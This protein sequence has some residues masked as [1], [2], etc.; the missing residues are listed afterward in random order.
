MGKAQSPLLGFNNNVKHR[1]RVFHIQT[2]D[3]GIKY[4]HVITH[5]FAD[6]GRILKSVKTSYAEYLG[7]EDLQETVRNL[8]KEQH[9]SMF[10]ALRDGQFDDL[11]EEGSSEPS[12][13][14]PSQT[15]EASSAPTAAPATPAGEPPRS[16]EPISVDVDALERA[17]AS[18]QSRSPLFGG[19]DMPPPPP[20][21][22]PGRRPS[23]SYR[24]VGTDSVDPGSDKATA[25]R[26]SAT[27]PASIF[28]TSS[29]SESSSS[30]FGEDVISG[31]SLDEVILSFLAE[32]FGTPP[33]KENDRDKDKGGSK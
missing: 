5:L 27:R 18:V 7:S 24:A 28:G 20:A 14:A 10:I 11:I 8:M 19:E 30:V 29:P 12:K 9:K 4:P 17:A 1:G 31:K 6:G 33:D 23:G 32:E 21:V 25:G 16:R 3:S 22:L 13:R 2:E 15:H 26:Y